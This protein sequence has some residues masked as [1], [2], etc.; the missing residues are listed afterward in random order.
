VRMSVQVEDV[1]WWMSDVSRGTR[2]PTPASLQGRYRKVLS[3]GGVPAV[4]SVPNKVGRDCVDI[5]SS[6]SAKSGPMSLVDR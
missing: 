1:A 4:G 2:A 3:D 5:A 6:T